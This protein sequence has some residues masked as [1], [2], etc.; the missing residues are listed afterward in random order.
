M[1][2]RPPTG[3]IRASLTW[4]VSTLISG[5]LLL[6]GVAYYIGVL[7]P[8]GGRIATAGLAG[9][10]RLFEPFRRLH[11]DPAFQGT[12]IGLA[13]VKRIISRHEGRVWAES[14]PGAG[15]CFYFTVGGTG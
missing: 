15:A 11:A 6:F 10:G 12:G 3:S 7:M 5:A 1:S 8:Y 9:A 14:A 2:A 4:R 13:S